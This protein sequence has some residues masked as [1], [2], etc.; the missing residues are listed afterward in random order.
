MMQTLDEVLKQVR[1]LSEDEFVRQHLYPALTLWVPDGR[2]AGGGIESSL[3]STLED[4]DFYLL[5]AM[6]TGRNRVGWL[7]KS[8]NNVFGNII[9]VG[10]ASS[11]DLQIPLETISK[12]HA[13]FTQIGS[14]WRVADRGA[15]NGLWVN[16]TQARRRYDR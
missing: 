3:H 10:R 15:T 13:V 11:N 7:Q 1:L 14:R 8:A 5:V 2:S 9:S 16:G 12:I 6:S 4:D